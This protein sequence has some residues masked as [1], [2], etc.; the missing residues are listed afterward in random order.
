MTW[1]ANHSEALRVQLHD[2]HPCG[3]IRTALGLVGEPDLCRGCYSV[4]WTGFS[5]QSDSMRHGPGFEPVH[6][7]HRSTPRPG[8]PQQRDT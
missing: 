6:T 3:Q 4:L 8:Q 2:N 5:N 7:E 1:T